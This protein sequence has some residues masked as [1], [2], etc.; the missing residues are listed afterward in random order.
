[1]GEPP[2]QN[3]NARELEWANH[4]EPNQKAKERSGERSVTTSLWE[5][6]RC[7]AQRPPRLCITPKASNSRYISIWLQQRRDSADPAI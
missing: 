4:L 7:G 3:Q 1:M 6:K 5:R 2:P